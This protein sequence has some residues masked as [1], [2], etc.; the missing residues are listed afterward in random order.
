MQK[1]GFDAGSKS[2]RSTEPRAGLTVSPLWTRRCPKQTNDH[3]FASRDDVVPLG[4]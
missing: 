3:S 1:R 2:D 4:C